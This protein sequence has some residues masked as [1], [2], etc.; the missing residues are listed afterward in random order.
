LCERCKK[1]TEV[2][3]DLLEEIGDKIY[4]NYGFK[5]KDHRVKFYGLCKECDNKDNKDNNDGFAT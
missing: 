2:E 5:I 3:D 1:I 4:G